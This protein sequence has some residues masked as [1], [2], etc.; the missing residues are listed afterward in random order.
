MNTR[1]LFQ[2]RCD[3]CEGTGEVDSGGVDMIG[4]FVNVTCPD[5]EGAG[6]VLDR[7]A[8]SG[9]I[10]NLQDTRDYAAPELAEHLTRQINILL[11]LIEPL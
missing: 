10:Q 5:C 7:A 9:R 6:T 4:H 11:D 1:Q 3:R 8:V 2:K